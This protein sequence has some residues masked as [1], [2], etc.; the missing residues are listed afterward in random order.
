MFTSRC[1]GEGAHPTL[2]LVVWAAVVALLAA[3]SVRADSYIRD[4]L[5]D[6]GS[7]PNLAAVPMYLS[8]DIWVRNSPMPG[9]NP[10]P[11][12]IASPPAWVD[13]THFNPDY[14][15][16]ASG[17][18][19]YVY[20]RIRNR[21]TTAST[22]AERL[23]LYV[24]RAS[25]GLSWDPAKAAGSFIDNVQAGAVLGMEITKVR[26]NAA[27]ATQAERDAYRNALLK[28]ATDPALVFSPSGTSYWRTQQEI[29]RFGPTYRH[30]FNGGTAACSG[31]GVREPS[32]GHL[33]R[34]MRRRNFGKKKLH[35]F[36]SQRLR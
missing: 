11:Y 26:K 35:F 3:G 20:V 30:G 15:S 2:V 21:G 6:T 14:A 13:S 16:P 27:T 4:D 22:G 8:P 24:A 23:L 1:R 7:E 19:N 17:K 36:R 33:V 25:T 34:V 32:G 18:P 31:V 9:W 12:S 29:H 28:I 5:A 10:Y